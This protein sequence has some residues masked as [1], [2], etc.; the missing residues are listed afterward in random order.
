MKG[1]E[2]KLIREELGL[3]QRQASELLGYSGKT[4]VS[5]LEAKSAHPA[6]L[7]CV[8]MRLL[9]RLSVKRSKE[10]QQQ[11]L[12]QAE[13]E[14]TVSPKKVKLKK[15]RKKRE[16]VSIPLNVKVIYKPVFEHCEQFRERRKQ[17]QEILARMVAIARKNGRPKLLEDDYEEAA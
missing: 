17:V 10:L 3:S 13:V 15:L 7:A 11:L 2:F 6:F 5:N 14:K 1:P 4:A 9:Q 12:E 8:V 16:V